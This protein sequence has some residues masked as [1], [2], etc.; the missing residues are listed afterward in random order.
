MLSV[1]GVREG[2]GMRGGGEPSQPAGGDEQNRCR[3]GG[4]EAGYWYLV[5]GGQWTVGSE[6]RTSS[7]GWLWGRGGSRAVQGRLPLKF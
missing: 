1:C 2:I 4:K 3:R 7:L 6:W 5:P